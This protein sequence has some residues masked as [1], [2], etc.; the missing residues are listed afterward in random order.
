[1][2]DTTEVRRIRNLEKGMRNRRGRKSQGRDTRLTL[3]VVSET[4]N[5]QSCTFVRYWEGKTI[6]LGPSTEEDPV[7]PIS[8]MS[9]VAVNAS[10]RRVIYASRR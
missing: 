5:I 2:Y 1:M 3:L 6:G 8:A 10:C 9:L 4:P 7:A